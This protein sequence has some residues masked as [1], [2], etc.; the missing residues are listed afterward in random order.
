MYINDGIAGIDRTLEGIGGF[1]RHNF[2]DLCHVQQCCHAGHSVL[3][4]GGGR[5]DDIVVAGARADDDL[6]LFGG[7]EDFGGDL[8]AA[9]DHRIDVGDRGQ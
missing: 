6:Q 8:V 5:S 7:I 4:V 3:A 1:D 9:D 2:R